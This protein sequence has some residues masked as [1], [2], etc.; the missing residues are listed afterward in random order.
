MSFVASVTRA[1][2]CSAGLVLR[3]LDGPE[4]TYYDW[5]ARRITMSRCQLDDAALLEQIM[6]VRAAHEF[7]R[8]LQLSTGVAGAAPP[9]RSR[10]QAVVTSTPAASDLASPARR[11]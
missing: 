1:H 6:K 10:S 2:D 11:S 8:H 9:G 4:S 7:R 3:V 5:R